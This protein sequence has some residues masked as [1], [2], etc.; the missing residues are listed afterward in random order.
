[1]E[2][3]IN[4]EIKRIIE[5]GNGERMTL[6]EIIA[7][8]IKEFFASPQFAIVE[9]AEQYYRNR[10]AVQQKTT[11]YK[12]RSN[13]K[14]EHPILR[15][16]V[17]QKANYLL[18]KP[19]SIESE[20]TAYAD[21]LNLL[22]DGRFRQQIKS[23]GKGAV[24]SGISW[25]APYFE[26]SQLKWMRLPSTEVVPVWHD[27]EHT[28]LDAYI[29]VYSQVVYNG[30]NKKTITRIEWWDRQGVKKYKAPWPIVG[31]LALEPDY[32]SDPGTNE[33][34]HFEIDGKPYNWDAVPIVWCKYN[35]EE[36]PLQYF[37]KELIDDINWQTS[38]TA[39]VLRDVAKFIFV[40][41]NYGG[42]DID[43]FTRELYEAL[44]IEVEG[45]GGVDK[46]EPSL[47]MDAVMAFLEKNR[48][49]L[50][51]FGSGV[52]TKD[53]DLGNASGTAINFRYMDL[54]TDCAALGAELQGAFEN[55]KVFLDAALAI[56]GKGD[57]S[58]E[59]FHVTFNADM[60]VNEGDVITNIRNSDGIISKHT[61]LANHPWVDDVEEELQRI[62]DEKVEEMEEF[63]AQMFAEDFA[64]S[65]QQ[66]QQGGGVNGDE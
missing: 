6:P 48:R 57:F 13:T 10:S 12:N 35:E 44:A 34:S 33:F 23:F 49:D 64:G 3:T 56:L 31:T 22:M 21:A 8:E 52:D 17:D 30:R 28:Q 63:G 50:F 58:K 1:M 9:E 32:D 38:I 2:I 20:S 61:Q 29:R 39:D 18:S 65:D 24:K 37:I 47:N 27:Y 40:L 60:P 53:P 11:K 16:L 14:I 19:F 15:K 5:T 55:M 7:Q 62:K 36:L 4:E 59:T 45:D 42:Q 51:D 25:L 41:R 54:D 43:R 26:D 46:L 66:T